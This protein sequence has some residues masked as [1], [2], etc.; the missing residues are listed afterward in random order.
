MLVHDRLEQRLQV[1]V[2]DATDPTEFHPRLSARPD[3]GSARIGLFRRLAASRAFAL[4]DRS[5]V[6]SAAQRRSGR[7]F[8]LDGRQRV[9]VKALVS[10]HIGAGAARGTALARHVAYLGRSGAGVE[11]ARPVFFDRTEDR[12]DPAARTAGWTDDRHHF[13]LI[14]SPEHA[15][16]IADL[17]AYVREV[18]AR[19]AADLGEPGLD[20]VG[21]CHFDT[22]NPHAHV[23]VRG[24]RADGRDLVI[25]R[26]Y[27]A[28]GLRGRAQEVAQELLG[29][30]TRVEA[31]R[32]IWRETQADRF[33][34]FDRRLVAAV[35]S[36]G[37]VADG[38]GRSD[39]WSA[40]TR[41]RLRRLEG[42]GLAERVG[43]RYRLDPNLEPKL[44]SLQLRR[45]IIRTLNQRRL[46]GARTVREL[47]SGRL[48]GEVMRSG[49]HDELGASPW[50][51]VRDE[52]GVEHYARLALGQAP[53]AAGQTVRLMAGARGAV[54]EAGLGRSVGLGL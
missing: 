29:D 54:L 50:T 53:P 21:A 3:T 37:L 5:G 52:A 39:A 28:Y 16:R 6:L 35:E 34:A 48:S 8:R 10:R 19:V 46:D 20:W 27:V 40:L 13:R 7:S 45:D 23:L 18:M 12:L 43:S 11:G 25:P 31:E 2:C 51:I 36:D 41:G 49:F 44:R 24:K 38:V 1:A 4:G 42:L 32:R 9:V 22:D 17:P 33:T 26:E 30:L 14:V 47:T 15:D